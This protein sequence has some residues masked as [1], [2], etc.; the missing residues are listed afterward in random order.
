VARL[1]SDSALLLF[2]QIL[3]PGLLELLEEVGPLLHE[4]ADHTQDPVLVQRLA[5]LDLLVADRA[6]D[7]PDGQQAQGV[8]APHRLLHVGFESF[9]Q[10]HG[11]EFPLALLFW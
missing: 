4:A 11:I 6:A 9:S 3:A 10:R 5:D 2:H 7:P 1:P 8:A